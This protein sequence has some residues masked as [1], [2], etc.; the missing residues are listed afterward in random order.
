MD[1]QDRQ[2]YTQS[3]S[4]NVAPAAAVDV[5]NDTRMSGPA[6]TQ[7]CIADNGSSNHISEVSRT[8]F[9]V[10]SSHNRQLSRMSSEQAL[11]HYLG[12][13]NVDNHGSG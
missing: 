5:Q 1:D 3:S 13:H 10:H 12:H 6:S 8:D 9:R 4:S 2:W 7:Q 11:D